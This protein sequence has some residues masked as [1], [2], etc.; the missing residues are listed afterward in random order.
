MPPPACVSAPPA[1]QTTLQPDS[2]WQPAPLLSDTLPHS[3]GQP[4]PSRMAECSFPNGR[5]LLIEWPP[6]LS[7]WQLASLQWDAELQPA[8]ATH[9]CLLQCTWA[10]VQQAQKQN[11]RCMIHTAHS[12]KA[13]TPD[14]LPYA[15]LC[16]ICEV[17]TVEP[18]LYMLLVTVYS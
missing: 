13:L 8:A 4:A 10:S 16:F 17:Y 15:A 12:C 3:E 6:A 2:E 14:Q 7:E 5:M 11:L 1:S 18:G 9:M